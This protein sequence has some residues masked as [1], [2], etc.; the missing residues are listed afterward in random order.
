M[1]KSTRQINE[2]NFNEPNPQKSFDVLNFGTYPLVLLN[3]R[4]H[5]LKS[6]RTEAHF[7]YILLRLPL[8][9]INHLPLPSLSL[10]ISPL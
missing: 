6:A 8:H 10:A 3:L 4:A 5:P 9:Y 2:I 1:I 7:S